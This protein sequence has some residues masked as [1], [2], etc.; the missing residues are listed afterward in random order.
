MPVYEIA[1]GPISAVNSLNRSEVRSGEMRPV[2]GR[3]REPGGNGNP[4]L[5]LLSARGWRDLSQPGGGVQNK[6]AG[7]L[8]S[9]GRVRGT[10]G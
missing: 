7:E 4:P 9:G 3:K 8:G 2:R 1:R 10:R 5:A 6:S